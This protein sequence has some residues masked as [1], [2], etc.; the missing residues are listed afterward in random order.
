MKNNFTN[1]FLKRPPISPC[2]NDNYYNNENDY[3][4]NG[5]NNQQIFESKY[6]KFN[7]S[8]EYLRTTINVFP[9]SESQLNKANIPIGLIISPSSFFVQEG[10][11][12]IMSYD[13]NDD[14]PRC[15]NENCKAFLNPFL[16]FLEDST[17][18]ECNFCKTINSTEDY[19]YNFKENNNIQINRDN[20]PILNNGSY[21]IILNKSYRKNNR[22][23]NTPNYYFLID[24][25]YKS[26][27]SG[28]SQ[29]ALETIKDCI[30]NNFF[31]N[32]EKFNIKICII[33]YDISIHFYS[34]NSKS[35][36]FSMMCISDNEIFIP[37]NRDNLLISLKDN[38]DKLI[39]LIESIQNNIS[40][41]LL[42]KNSEIKDGTKIFDSVK[43]VNL[44]GGINGGKI[45]IFSGSNLN[46]LEMM[47]DSEE[48]EL[49]KV[50]KNL[51]RGG[52][53]LSQLGIE[54][55][56][57]NFSVDI[58]QSSNEFI[59]LISINQLCDNTNGNIYFY[60]NFNPD[61]H[62]KN[63][64]N[65]IKRVLT[66]ELHLEGTL[67]IRFSKGIYIKK[68]LTSVLFYKKKLFV[69]PCH[70]SDEKYSVLLSMLSEEEM[71]ENQLPQ[72]FDDFFYIQSC[73]L[74]SYGDG[75]RRMRVHNLCFP[76]SS[77]NKDIFD[78]I[79]VECLCAIFA[80]KLTHSIYKSKNFANS[81]IKIE[82]NCYNLINEYFNYNSNTIKRE[83]NNDMQMFILY[84]LGIMKLNLF[85]RDN[86]KGYL[87]DIDLSNYYRLKLLK[88][89]VEEIILFI[90]PR[91]YILDNCSNYG[92]SPEIVNDSLNSLNQGSIF[93]IDN[94]FFLALYFRKNL[95][96]SICQDFFGVNSFDEI[97]Y[98]EVNE[99]N[100]FDNDNNN[101][102]FINII[103]EIIDNI[104]NSKSLF[105]DLFFIFEGIN[106]ENIY[107]EILI[108]DNYNKN[109]PYDYNKFY[110]KIISGN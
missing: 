78:S 91:I 4:Q 106:D 2:I 75:T 54:L 70:D 60:K 96:K 52:K 5:K 98:L 57:N 3:R 88:M 35:S 83:L 72:K 99:S 95:N 73:L 30:N 53:K 29:C 100:I 92:N 6:K 80:Q 44:L 101:G 97:N 17:K 110:N 87:N 40:N 63:L 25:S 58:F 94:G 67:K 37:T 15:K 11:I 18:W 107:K 66:N 85:N 76:T 1:T 24:I 82:D 33:T 56:Y 64:Y 7:C 55:T 26:I 103:R 89:S 93:L 108:E 36:Q 45:L 28:F 9:K 23:P 84:F 79:D 8:K 71:K 41:N 14:A 16:K 10:D 31:Y 68:Y 69:F 81:V 47:K 109:F 12:P 42:N 51:I 48:E 102:E 21:E 49:N 13:E 32:Y 38:K 65:Q 34:L 59:K 74:Y 77:N 19:Y 27:I 39:A 43:S 22:I 46:S 20:I 61:I 62:Y 86:D 105:Q 50:N 104:R 90:Y